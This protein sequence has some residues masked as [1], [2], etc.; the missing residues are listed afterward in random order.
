M[1]GGTIVLG[2]LSASTGANHFTVRDLGV[3]AGLKYINAFNSGVPTNA[4]VIDKLDKLLALR[5]SNHPSLITL[6][7]SATARSPQFIAC[8][9]R[10]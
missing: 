4:L 3:D 8:W 6:P 9:L 7:V 10:M 1:V 2:Q 5:R